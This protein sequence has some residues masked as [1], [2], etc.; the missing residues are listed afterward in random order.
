M[1]GIIGILNLNGQ[2]VAPEILTAMTRQLSHRGPNDEG[3]YVDS[4]APIGFGHRRLSILDLTSN[5]HQPMVSSDNRLVIT[6]N[7]EIYNF[8]EIRNLLQSDG[9]TFHSTSD[10]EVILAAF[11]KWGISCLERFDGMF[12]FGIWDKKTRE[13]ILARDRYGIKP[14]YMV[15]IPN[16]A[17]LFA[18]E[19]KAFFPFP[20]FDVAI[21]PEGLIE[22]LGFQNFFTD[23]TLFKNVR[24][25]DAGSYRRISLQSS[26]LTEAKRYWDFSFDSSSFSDTPEQAEEKIASLFENAVRK[27]LVSDVTV[28]SYLSGG[29]D[30]GSITGIAS[31]NLPYLQTFTCGFDLSS[32][33][34]IELTFDE[35]RI[36]EQLSNLFKSEHYEIVLKAGD[37]E[38]CMGALTW[39][40]EEPRVGQSYP[41][42]YSSKL[43]SK[44]VKVCLSGSGGDELFAGY[45]WRY[46]K[47]SAD[48]SFDDYVDHYFGFWQRML[49]GEAY[50]K[51]VQPL[52]SS[53]ATGDPKEIFR[54]VL[55]QIPGPMNSAE[56]YINRSL[57]FEAK[58]FLHGL[59][60]VED[61]LSMAHGLETRVPFLDNDLVDYAMTIPV[62]LKLSNIDTITRFNENENQAKLSK[63]FNESTD[64]KLILR[65]VMKRFVPPEV[66]E[67]RKQG[68]SAPD[69][70]WFKG[71][72]IEFVRRKILSPKAKIYQYL[73]F[74]TVESL[75]QEH[76]TGAVNRRLLIWSLVYLES[77]IEQFI[78]RPKHELIGVKQM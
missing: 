19:V 58:T 26:V 70:S 32:A 42:Y 12:A 41:I 39:H 67:R 31:R 35:R 29:I 71:E 46:F 45:P 20:S 27:Q 40:L 52:R 28:G 30:S 64:G 15:E 74:A 21:D 43:A 24:M 22:Y 56:D 75:V 16:Q 48:Q 65:H 11:D 72:S 3:I 1:C 18:S 77:F 59:L 60:V 13:L 76:L 36:A 2:P 33:S 51:V 38:R 49:P 5:G 63:F 69:A 34:G 9:Y 23:K 66:S 47:A 53:G 54:S 57:C 73:D 25:L 44:F 55:S 7:G 78:D 50:A 37:M 8:I 17:F 61:K 62:H 68:F 14:L 4:D 10:T 6:F